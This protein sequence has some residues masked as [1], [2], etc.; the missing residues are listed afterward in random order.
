MGSN[1]IQFPTKKKV[2]TEEE[3]VQN[4]INNELIEWAYR[5]GVD[6]N[7]LEFKYSAAAIMACMQGMIL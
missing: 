1:V 2:E 4:F 7:S 5:M 6:T 3:S